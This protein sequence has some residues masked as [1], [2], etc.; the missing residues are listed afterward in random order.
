M[1]RHKFQS[2]PSAWRETAGDAEHVP[3]FTIFQ[4]T[5]SAWRETG[6]SLDGNVRRAISIHSLRVEGDYFRFLRIGHQRISIHSLRVEGDLPAY[7]HSVRFHDFNPLPPR[8]GRLGDAISS[9]A[10]LSISIH[11]LRVEGDP[12]HLHK[13]SKTPGFQSTPSAWRETKPPPDRQCSPKQFQS[14]PSAW[15]ETQKQKSGCRF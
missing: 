11:S 3:D 7:R 12:R 5:P 15:R 14:T 9:F 4:S 13:L 1:N 6:S 8:G 10:D 2:T